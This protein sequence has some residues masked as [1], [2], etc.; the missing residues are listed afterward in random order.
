MFSFPHEVICGISD[1]GT[2]IA[3]KMVMTKMMTSKWRLE[4]QVQRHAG[5]IS[6][7]GAE[8]DLL[9]LR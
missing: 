6:T 7:I 2:I 3:E 5:S 9:K 1:I 4:N 8:K